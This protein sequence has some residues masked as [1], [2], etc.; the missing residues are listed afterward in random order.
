MKINQIAH[1]MMR[2]PWFN[3][4]RSPSV[5]LKIEVKVGSYGYEFPQELI[6]T[7][8]EVKVFIEKLSV[9]LNKLVVRHC[10]EDAEL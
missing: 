3:D 4:H 1:E 6:K 7:E 5:D 10:Y 9:T 8:A 2:N